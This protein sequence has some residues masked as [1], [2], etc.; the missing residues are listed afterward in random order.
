MFLGERRVYSVDIR[1]SET[2]HIGNPEGPRLTFELGPVP[3]P[4]DQPTTRMRQEADRRT[5]VSSIA[6]TVLPAQPRDASGAEPPRPTTIGRAFGNDVVIPDVLASGHHA[7]LVTTPEGVRIQDADSANGTF[8]NGQR[9]KNAALKPN[10]VVTIRQRRLCVRERQSRP[11]HRT[12][13][14]DRWPRRVRH[15]LDDRRQSR[16]AGPCFVLRQAG[17]VDRGDRPVGFGQDQ[18]V[19][20]DRGRYAAGQRCSVVRGARR[21]RRVRVDAHPDRHGSARRR[22]ASSADHQPGLGLRGGTAD[23]AGHHQGRP[24]ARGR[25]GARGTR[26]DAARGHPH[27][28]AVGRAAQTCIGRIGVVDRSVA[29]GARRAH[30][31]TGPRAGP[32]GDEDAAPARRRRPRRRG[33]DAFACLPGCLRSS[34]VACSRRQDRILWTAQ[35]ARTGDGHHRLGRH[36]HRHQRGSRRGPAAI[37]RAGRSCRRAANPA[38]AR[39]ARGAESA[40]Q[41]VAPVLDARAPTAAAARRRPRLLRVLGPA[42]VHRRA[43]AARRG[44]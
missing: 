3:R 32:A 11:S 5:D 30:D 36:L 44:R 2:I 19:E 38:R 13:R 28:K 29:A 16:T 27:R 23:A 4:D 33:R 42:A 34:A 7:T 6:T 24:A 43:A 37:S 10:D 20:G 40:G 1:D 12:R 25:A 15:Q 35:R 14:Q 41:P 17:H 22:R 9:V 8:V 21:P 31:R 18:F 26:V 39:A